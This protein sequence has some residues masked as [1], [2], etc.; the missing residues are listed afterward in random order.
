MMV[1]NNIFVLFNEIL[2][3]GGF[4]VR[5]VGLFNAHSIYH[6][7]HCLV[8]TSFYANFAIYLLIVCR[9]TPTFLK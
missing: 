6:V 1:T 7:H 3:L 5:I 9:Y 4:T 2:F 8:I